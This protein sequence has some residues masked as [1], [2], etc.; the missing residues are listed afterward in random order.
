MS[1]LTFFP[2]LSV[3]TPVGTSKTSVATYQTVSTTAYCVRVKPLASRNSTTVGSHISSRL[4][5]I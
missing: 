1:I 2:Y 5:K 4:K 3:M